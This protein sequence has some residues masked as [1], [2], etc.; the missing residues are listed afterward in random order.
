MSLKVKCQSRLVAMIATCFVTCA[1]HAQVN[2]ATVPLI[3]EGNRPFVEVTFR[4]ADGSER[5]ARFL[6]DSGGGAFIIAEPLAR[7]I[8]LT[9][10]ESQKEEGKEFAIATT[11][12]TA[13]VGGVALELN[14]QRVAVLLA[15][16]NIL[17][18]AAPGKAEGMFPGHVLARYHVIFDYPKG[19]FTLAKP[20][21]LKPQGEAPHAR[22]QAV[23]VPAHGD[24]S[25]SPDLRLPYR[26]R[27]I[28][29]HGL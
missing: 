7:D 14:P 6:V 17:P 15:A 24:R 21:V 20:G 28:L 2:Q 19:E 26:H 3:L 16:D 8:G 23:R 11:L 1:A 12:P 9:W 18:A 22:I 13:S 27:G 29:H 25:R 10:G 5:A 4:K